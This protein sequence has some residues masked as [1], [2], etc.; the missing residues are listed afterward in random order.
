MVLAPCLS[1]E[2]PSMAIHVGSLMGLQSVLYTLAVLPGRHA[3]WQSAPE[4]LERLQFTPINDLPHC[5]DLDVDKGV[6]TW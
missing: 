3:L 2:Y 1:P 6:W 4:K 5:R